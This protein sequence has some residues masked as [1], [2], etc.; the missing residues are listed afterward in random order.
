MKITN[1]T[2]PAAI[3]AKPN[4]CANRKDESRDFASLLKGGPSSGSQPAS[5]PPSPAPG[6]ENQS[7][8][9][10]IGRLMTEAQ[11]KTPAAGPSGREARRLELLEDSLR[12]LDEY[13]RALADPQQALKALAS[14]A[15]SLEPLAGP[16]S[17]AGRE[18][19]DPV[20]RDLF[21]R[22]AITITVETMKFKRGDY[23]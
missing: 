11:Q 10:L 15:E 16:L 18:V 2:H 4:Q 14:L 12:S 8:A 9:S 21:D 3:E 19:D 5:S 1:Q 20:L 6:W 13:A 23:V 22:T 7:S 17:Q